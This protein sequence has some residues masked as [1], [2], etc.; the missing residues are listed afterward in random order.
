MEGN[1]IVLPLLGAL[2]ASIIG[3]AIWALIGVWTESELGV[4]AWAIGGLTGFTVALL[5]NKQVAVAHQ[6]VAVIA[7]LLGILLGKYFMF[8]YLL[9][10]FE[11]IFNS[12]IFTLFTENIR[13]FFQGMDI[14][15]IALAVITAWQLPKQLSRNNG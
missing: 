7:S 12:E 9:G 2:V 8:G 14:L 13:E 11:G 4:I 5:A 1:K 10:E 6:V 15:F 3:G